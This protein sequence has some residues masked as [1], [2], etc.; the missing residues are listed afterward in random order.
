MTNTIKIIG[1]MRKSEKDKGQV[2][3]EFKYADLQP[4]LKKI[5]CEN[6]DLKWQKAKK[7]IEKKTGRAIAILKDM[8]HDI[9]TFNELL[10][11]DRS[12][13]EI[14]LNL[15]DEIRELF[16]I[17]DEINIHNLGISLEDNLNAFLNIVTV[18]HGFEV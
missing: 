6:S 4:M 17:E 12:E 1:K 14:L 13:E 15:D 11:N 5:K 16:E 2:S 8:L 3:I 10:E 9:E 7:E 18:D